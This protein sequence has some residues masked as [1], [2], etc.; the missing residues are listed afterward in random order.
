MAGWHHWLDG[1]ELSELRELVMDRRAMI[2]GV[3]KSQTRL[4]N[5]TELIF[6]QSN[7]EKLYT[8]SKS[9]TGSWLWLRSWSPYCQV[10]SESESPSVVSN[11]LGAHWLYIPRNSPGQNTGMGRVTFPFSRGSSQPRDETQV[12]HIAGG[13]FT[14]WATREAPYCKFRLKECRENH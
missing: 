12:S 5:W 2:H 11:S 1:H 3:A 7:M 6:L 14:S 10:N 9:K 8:V 13:F 4:S